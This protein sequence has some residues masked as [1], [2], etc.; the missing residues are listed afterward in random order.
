MGGRTIFLACRGAAM[1][2]WSRLVTAGPGAAWH[3]VTN[4]VGPTISQA[5]PGTSR[6]GP[7]G[8]DTA[9]HGTTW[10]G[11]ACHDSAWPCSAQQG[12]VQA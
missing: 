3:G 4:G 6:L 11:A 7:A 8:Q 5:R 12:E 1:R 9:R 2:G 10:Q